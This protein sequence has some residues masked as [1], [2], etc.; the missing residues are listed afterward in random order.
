MATL[1]QQRRGTAAEWTAV[2]PILAAGE[3]GVEIDTGIVKVGDGVTTWGNLKTPY[4]LNSGGTMRAPLAST[5]PLVVQGNENQ[6]ADLIRIV[7]VN[8]TVLSGIDAAG[9]FFQTGIARFSAKGD[10]LVGTGSDQSSRLATGS[11][12]LVLTADPSTPTGMKWSAVSRA[13]DVQIFT[14]SGTWTKQANAKL[15]TVIAF[16][17]GQSGGAVTTSTGNSYATTSGGSGGVRVVAD[18]LPAALADSI[19]VTVGAGGAAGVSRYV[20]NNTSL[21]NQGLNPGGD[22]IFGPIRARGAGTTGIVA[23]TSSPGG[24]YQ[25]NIALAMPLSPG[26]GGGFSKGY[27]NQNLQYEGSS[28]VGTVRT[29]RSGSGLGGDGGYGA[30]AQA[31]DGQ[32]PGGGGGASANSYTTYQDGNDNTVVSFDGRAT[33][34]AGARGEVIVI[35]QF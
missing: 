11:L 18:L 32:A 34:G 10:I 9:K 23:G 6:T 3:I 31:G 19:S 30:K 16:G 5:T 7:D 12:G 35:T 25:G 1:M 2:N 33:S 20:S 22:S 26:G 14:A 28:P 17:G 13:A 21:M 29:A 15:V 4:I 27:V 24:D 8:G